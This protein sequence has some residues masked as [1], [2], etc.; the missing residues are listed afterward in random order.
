M[1]PPRRLL[2]F[3]GRCP[4]V[5]EGWMDAIGHDVRWADEEDELHNDEHVTPLSRCDAICMYRRNMEC[6]ASISFFLE[7]RT[8]GTDKRVHV[9]SEE[10]LVLGAHPSC[11]SKSHCSNERWVC[12]S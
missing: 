6:T 8:S 10:H 1:V 12:N 2:G 5:P 4:P 9:I 3:R 7:S 11:C